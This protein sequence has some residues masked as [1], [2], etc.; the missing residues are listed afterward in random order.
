MESR[1]FTLDEV[2]KHCTESDAWIAIHGCVYDVTSWL[3]HHPGGKEIILKYAGY[4]ASDQFEAFHCPEMR[5]YLKLYLIGSLSESIITTK[6]GAS[7]DYRKLR[8]RLWKEGYFKQNHTYLLQRHLLWLVL[9][10]LATLLLQ[11]S[12]RNTYSSLSLLCWYGIS[13]GSIS[14][15]RCLTQ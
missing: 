3:K 13:P 14:F 11:S 5:K 12:H 15:T 6:M 4:D 7:A 2:A 1:F 10:L 9:S 8:E